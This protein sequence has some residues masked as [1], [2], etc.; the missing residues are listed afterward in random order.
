ML[1]RGTWA[2]NISLGLDGNIVF[3]LCLWAL[4][5][6]SRPLLENTI[7]LCAPVP[8]RKGHAVACGGS[9][10]YMS[11]ISWLLLAEGAP[12]TGSHCGVY[13][14]KG[15]DCLAFEL[16]L[17]WFVVSRGDIYFCFGLPFSLL[18]ACRHL[19]LPELLSCTL[20]L[21]FS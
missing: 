21:I 10:R 18:S 3:P 11:C 17:A 7:F 6:S 15:L 8:D 1:Y 5:C 4:C 9:P 20:V 16:L 13:G 14:C 2:S 19:L 12:R